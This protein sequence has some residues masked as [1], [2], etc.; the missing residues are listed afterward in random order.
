MAENSQKLPQRE[1][2]IFK[3]IVVSGTVTPHSRCFACVVDNSV[4]QIE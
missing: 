3:K 2:G 4:L 1:A